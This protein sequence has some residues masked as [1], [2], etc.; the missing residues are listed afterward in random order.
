MFRAIGDA[1][2]YVITTPARLFRWFCACIGNLRQFL[3]QR[4]NHIC[5]ALI[6]VMMAVVGIQL[7][8]SGY[9]DLRPGEYVAVDDQ[10]DATPEKPSKKTLRAA[11]RDSLETI[12]SK[13]P[14]LKNSDGPT[15]EASQPP[16]LPDVP[17]VTV[18]KQ[19]PVTTPTASLTIPTVPEVKKPVARKKTLILPEPKIVD[20]SELEQPEKPDVA[21][22]R[23]LIESDDDGE[24]ESMF[25]DDD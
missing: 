15:A 20:L 7:R 25:G 11:I 4:R 3:D 12:K 17:V 19:R 2:W 8:H 23:G 21:Q 18:S 24:P 9:A 1:I 14:S 22:L 10:K 6:A 16:A 5:A 13:L